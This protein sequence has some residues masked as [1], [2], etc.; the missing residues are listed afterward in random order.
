MRKLIMARLGITGSLCVLSTG[1]SLWHAKVQERIDLILSE[2]GGA[3]W[4]RRHAGRDYQS[5]KHHNNY[6]EHL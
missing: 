6:L 3:N 1:S 5:A 4:E 2:F